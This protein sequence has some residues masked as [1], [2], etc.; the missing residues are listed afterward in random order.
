[1]KL[2][3]ATHNP[4][5]LAEVQSML[6]ENMKILGLKDINCEEDIPETQD[7][8]QGN[9]LQKARFVREHY[10]CFCFSDDTGLEI[11]ALDGRPGVLS[12]RYAGEAKDSVANMEKVLKE[13]E[14]VENRK[15]RF[16]TV[17]ALLLEDEELLFEGVAEGEIIKEKRGVEGF[18]YD[19]IFVP[20]GY[21]QTFAEMPLHEKNRISHR[22]KAFNL[23]SEYLMS[24]NYF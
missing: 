23:L 19:P 5:K 9:A 1:M 24:L 7:T 10:C 20:K 17:I 22:Y 6:P 8:L 14:G 3:F 18:G 16:K 12:A 21:D 15:A 2:V 13:L 11:D 4:H